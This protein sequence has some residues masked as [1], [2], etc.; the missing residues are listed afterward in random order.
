LYNG[1]GYDFVVEFHA[2]NIPPEIKPWLEVKD[3][4]LRKSCH[5]EL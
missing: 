5:N 4:R 2:V 1:L 3:F